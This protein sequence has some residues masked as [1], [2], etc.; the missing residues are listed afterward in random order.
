M[1]ICNPGR[2]DLNSNKSDRHVARPSFVGGTLVPPSNRL[3]W[4]FLLFAAGC[5]CL[6]CGSKAT[7]ESFHPE[8][9]TAKEAL[10]KALTA[11]KNGQEQPGLIAGTSKPEI[12]VAD[13]HWLQGAKLKS[14]E[15]GEP[16]D[17]DGPARF[18]VKLTFE[19]A[20]AP[21]EETY[22]IVGK[23]PLWV[24]SKAESDRSAG[25]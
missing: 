25:M 13:E 17:E 4:T 10:E 5:L 3:V 9:M 22:M 2:A 8:D 14:F 12:R 16:L 15:I 23:D 6:G 21:A 11:W 7:V 18:P 24:M 20:S 1:K 19:G